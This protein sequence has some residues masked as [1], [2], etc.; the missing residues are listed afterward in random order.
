M[1]G[2]V[3]VAGHEL[4]VAGPVV[5][6]VAVEVV[7]VFGAG[8]GPAQEDLHHEPVLGILF[9]VIR[10]AEVALAGG[11]TPGALE[12]LSDLALAGLPACRCGLR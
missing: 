4:E 2:E 3:A 11:F 6:R 1:K 8:A 12:E 9:P 7:D 5:V 10:G